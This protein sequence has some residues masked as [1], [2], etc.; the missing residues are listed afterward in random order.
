MSRASAVKNAKLAL[1]VVVVVFAA[2]VVA[3]VGL[4]VTVGSLSADQTTF[5]AIGGAIALVG[6]VQVVFAEAFTVWLFALLAGETDYDSVEVDSDDVR[7]RRLGGY[8][9]LVGGAVAMAFAFL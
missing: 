4:N 6:L 7:Q 2:A 1:G 8:L 5:L 3:T 9:M